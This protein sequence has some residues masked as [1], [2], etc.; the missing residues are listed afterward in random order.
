MKNEIKNFYLK[1]KKK[2]I[3]GS[4]IILGAVVL[5]VLNSKNKE[6]VLQLEDIG[7]LSGHIDNEREIEIHYVDVA[8]N[9]ILWKDLCTEEYVN[10]NRE[11]GMQYDTIRKLNGIEEA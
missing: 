2:I 4:G 5:A 11:V 7:K 1:H 10:D 8:T 6:G 9:Q 3:V